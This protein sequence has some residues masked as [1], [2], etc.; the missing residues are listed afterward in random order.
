M[1]SWDD[2]EWPIILNGHIIEYPVLYFSVGESFSHDDE[3]TEGWYVAV[4]NMYLHSDL[5]LRRITDNPNCNI[6]TGFFSSEDEALSC[7]ND[8][9]KKVTGSPLV[10]SD[11]VMPRQKYLN[12]IVKQLKK[13]NAT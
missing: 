11:A 10:N 3:R 8:Y 6:Y 1:D 9:I 12:D 13:H 2:I 4:D 7:I 5:E